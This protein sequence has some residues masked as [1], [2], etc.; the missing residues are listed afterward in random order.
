MRINTEDVAREV[1]RYAEE[2]RTFR[3]E[4]IANEEG[5]PGG[6]IRLQVTEEGWEVHTGDPSYDTDHRGKWGASWVPAGA[7]KC[8]CILI[9]VDLVYEACEGE[10]L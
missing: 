4:D 6:D 3:P 9:A 5:K 7:S 10:G 8:E 2:L 1:R